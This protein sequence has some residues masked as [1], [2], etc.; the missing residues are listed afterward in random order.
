DY[1][2]DP[3]RF[4]RIS[5]GEIP[6]ALASRPGIF[7]DRLVLV[8]DDTAVD[9]LHPVPRREERVSGLVLQA[10]QVATLAAGS[11]V[12]EAPRAPFLALA[13]LWT[14]LAAAAVLLLRR[15][16][17]ALAVLLA[18]L[19]LYIALS[20]PAFQRTGQLWPVTPVLL[21]SLI[22]L[23]LAVILRRAL[24]PIPRNEET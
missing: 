7:R 20:F 3:A 17:P 5:W 18:G 14:A 12:R 21:P 13:A 6:G 15:P 23:A 16:A 8:G 11:P 9:D 19:L 2:I 24:S 4:G 10:L 1:R 22:A